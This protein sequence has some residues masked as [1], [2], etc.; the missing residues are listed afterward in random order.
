MQFYPFQGN[1][2][3]IYKGFVDGVQILEQYTDISGVNPPTPSPGP[4]VGTTTP[5]LLM[6]NL[7]EYVQLQLNQIG[8]PDTWVTQSAAVFQD[9]R[10]YNGTNKNYTASFDVS[11][12][13]KPIV[14]ARP[15]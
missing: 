2:Y 5:M 7:F 1:T 15:Y 14:V 8:T 3:T 4:N 11:T 10:F 6:G 13:V 12:T 9:F